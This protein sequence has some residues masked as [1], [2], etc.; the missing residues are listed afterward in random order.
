MSFT[1]AFIN[2]KKKIKDRPILNKILSL[3][4]S[5]HFIFLTRIKTHEKKMIIYL[6]TSQFY[7]DGCSLVFPFQY[8]KRK[9]NVFQHDKPRRAHFQAH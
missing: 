9:K 6:D 2:F 5:N 8:L 3:V 7:I 1:N 4:Y